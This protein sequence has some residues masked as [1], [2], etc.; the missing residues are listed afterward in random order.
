M[1]PPNKS[2]IAK[3]SQQNKQPKKAAKRSVMRK[4]VLRAP[5]A[6]S[7]IQR[8]SAPRLITSGQ[9]TIVRHSEFIGTALVSATTFKLLGNSAS[10]PGYDGNPGSELMFP[11]LASTANN[12]EKYRFNR[13]EIRVGTMASTAVP[14]RVYASWD[15]D[16]DDPVPNSNVQMCNNATFASGPAWSDLTIKI[17]CAKAFSDD[18]YKFVARSSRVDPEPRTT[19]CGYFLVA[20]EAVPI[21]T[22]FSLNVDYEVELV[23]P[24]LDL[25]V[26]TI[27]AGLTVTAPATGANVSQVPRFVSGTGATGLAVAIPGVN[28]VPQLTL[29]TAVDESTSGIASA[30][31]LGNNVRGLVN[32]LHTCSEPG[33]TPATLM[34]TETADMTFFDGAGIVLGTMAPNMTSLRATANTGANPPSAVNTAASDLR[35]TIS[36]D[37]LALKTLYPTVKYLIPVLYN[38]AVRAAGLKSTSWSYQS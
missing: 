34:L 4:E 23:T 3:K 29:G 30:L 31:D 12:F 32:I 20:T 6:V 26:P 38:T 15:Y 21:G 28:A 14:G 27:Q 25:V 17:D 24:C 11:W 7:S 13:L 8:F 16:Y 2:Q 18:K 37:L 9:K 10:T 35:T 5:V 22:Q 36:L 19:F 33:K 1:L